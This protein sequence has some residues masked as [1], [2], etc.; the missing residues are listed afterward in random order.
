M[1]AGTIAGRDGCTFHNTNLDA[2]IS[3]TRA[4]GLDIPWDT[5]HATE[6]KGPKGGAVPAQAWTLISETK[7]REG[8]I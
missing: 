8:V 2:V 6:I 4:A 5:E 7:I 3:V 1:P